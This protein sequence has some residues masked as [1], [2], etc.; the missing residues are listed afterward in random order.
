MLNVIK[1]C[2]VNQVKELILLSSSEVYQHANIIP[3][4]EEI[5]LIIPDIKIQ[6]FHMEG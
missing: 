4:P 6:D 5:P 3:T 2:E 1:A